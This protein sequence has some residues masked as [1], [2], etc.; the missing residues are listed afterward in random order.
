M[1]KHKMES[2]SKQKPFYSLWHICWQDRMLRFLHQFE[3]G[4]GE[5][6]VEREQW[7]TVPDVD[8]LGHV[9]NKHGQRVMRVIL[10]SGKDATQEK[11]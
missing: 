5:N 10:D 9:F 6:S 3:T 4:K 2:A 8:T 11:R 7:L 1:T